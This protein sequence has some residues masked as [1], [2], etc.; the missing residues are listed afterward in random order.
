MVIKTYE[1][2]LVQFA[3]FR[4]HKWSMLYVPPVLLLIGIVGNIFSFIILRQK[5]LRSQSTYLYLAVLAWADTIVLF[6]GLL[7]AWLGELGGYDLKNQE[8]WLCKS[9]SVVLHTASDFSVW[10]IIAV[11]VER[12]IVACHPL[13]A[14]AM[15]KSYRAKLVIITIFLAVFALNTH[16]AWTVRVVSLPYGSGNLTERRCQGVELYAQFFK[17]WSWVDAVKYSFLPLGIIAILNML[18]TTKVVGAHKRR[19][20]SGSIRRRRLNYRRSSVSEASTKLTVMLLAV[21]FSFL[22][23]TLPMNIALIISRFRPERENLHSIARFAL[24]NTIVTLLMY[25]NHAMN[26]Y[27]YCATGQ[28]FRKQVVRFLC[29]TKSRFLQMAAQS[30]A[31]SFKV[32]SLQRTHDIQLEALGDQPVS[33]KQ[34]SI[35]ISV[36]GHGTYL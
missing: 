27:L 6:M 3:E 1:R 10:L 30:T 4:L 21:S 23:T 36:K 14:V 17:V 15:C 34:S 9:T 20:L 18:I 12:Y 5:A 28:K 24:A 16:F 26:F 31:S 22:L 7:R 19:V 29:R 25:T 35:S 2:G 8:D 11:T 13:K 33:R 32:R